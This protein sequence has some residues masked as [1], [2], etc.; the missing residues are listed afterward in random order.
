M[1][2]L[3]EKDTKFK[4]NPQCEEA[5]LTLKKLITT[6]PVLPQPDIDKPFDVYCDA[7]ATGIGGVLMQDG[8][9]I[10]YASR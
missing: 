2:N 5:F 8:H 7:F 10:A 1:T 9:A 6:A 3:L 4:W